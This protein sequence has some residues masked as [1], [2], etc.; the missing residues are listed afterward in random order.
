M[1]SNVKDNDIRQ[2]IQK[3]LRAKCS[4]CSLQFT[5]LTTDSRYQVTLQ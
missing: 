3:C 2:S 1:Q 5:L 4:E